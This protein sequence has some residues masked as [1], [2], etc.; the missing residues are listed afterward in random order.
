MKTH[1]GHR[2]VFVDGAYS[3][4]DARSVCYAYGALAMADNA[5]TFDV[6]RSM[7]DQYIAGSGSA[8]GV[9]L[10]GRLVNDTDIWQCEANKVDCGANMPWSVREPNRLETERCVL[11]WYSRTD[12]VANYDCTKTMPAIC[13]QL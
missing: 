6:L 11:V 5:A 12:G 10:D 8:I 3:W 4:N 13:E 2:Y 1:K 7:Y 9:W